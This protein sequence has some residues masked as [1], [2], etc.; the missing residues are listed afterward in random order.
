MFGNVAPVVEALSEQDS[1]LFRDYYCAL[2]RRIGKLSQPARLGLSYD[3]TFLAILLDSLSKTEPRTQGQRR[4]PLH[5][6]KP[7]RHI[8][9]DGISYAADMSVLLIRAKVADDAKDEK[10]PFMNL[11]SAIIRDRVSS[12]TVERNAINTQLAALSQVESKNLHDEDMAADCFAV[13]CGKLF[14]PEGF[15][16]NTQEALYWLG[17]NIGRWIYLLDAYDDLEHDIK[18]GCYNPFCTGG[19]A[20]EIK[21]QRGAQIEQMLY[22]TLSEAAGAFDLLPINRYKSLLENII[23]IGL[24]ARQRSVMHAPAKGKQNEPI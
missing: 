4:C 1:R 17:Y 10:N 3:M 2:C 13:L 8:E 24:A 5:P 12:R 14:A 19:T 11:A 23:Y 22:Y 16:E 7:T 6:T 21:A 15:D 20:R 9:S 18:K